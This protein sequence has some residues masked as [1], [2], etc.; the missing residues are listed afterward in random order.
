MDQ[1]AKLLK[2]TILNDLDSSEILYKKGLHAQSIYFLQQAYEKTTK[3]ILNEPWINN[4]FK[5]EDKDYGHTFRSIVNKYYDKIKSNKIFEIIDGLKVLNTKNEK[6]ND[7]IKYDYNVYSKYF[8]TIQNILYKFDSIID[9]KNGYNIGDGIE[10]IEKNRD[11]IIKII[12]NLYDQVARLL[13]IS[14]TDVNEHHD[15]NKNH[16]VYGIDICY[17]FICNHD[18][19]EPY[20]IQLEKN[21]D[22]NKIKERIKKSITFYALFLISR[23]L[24]IYNTYC[25]YNYEETYQLNFTTSLMNDE[26]LRFKLWDLIIGFIKM[27]DIMYVDVI[28]YL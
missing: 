12:N 14:V 27:Y 4:Y 7:V 18:I 16:F 10:Y 8:A 20:K 6:N 15:T 24:S 19:I 22:E 1:K 21:I 25:R 28:E 5:S 2:Q 11:N 3:L 17:S 26:N 13:I 9:E 23:L